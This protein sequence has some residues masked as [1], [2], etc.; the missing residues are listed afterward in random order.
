ML[1]AEVEPRSST[2][3]G[4]SE[5][6]SREISAIPLDRRLRFCGTAGAEGWTEEPRKNLITLS[7]TD[8][9]HDCARTNY[10]LRMK[11]QPFQ[12]LS[13]YQLSRGTQRLRLWQ[14]A[15]W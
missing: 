1:L 12:L 2:H 13:E 7:A 5:F 14:P 15:A 3:K 6:S 9:I 4:S 10:V 11:T 8:A